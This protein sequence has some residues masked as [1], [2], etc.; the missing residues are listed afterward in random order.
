VNTDNNRKGPIRKFRISV[1]F[2]YR[3]SWRIE[4]SV[5]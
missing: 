4:L 5:W 3:T 2:F 1:R